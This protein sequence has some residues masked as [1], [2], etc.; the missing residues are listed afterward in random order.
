MRIKSSSPAELIVGSSQ[1]IDDDLSD[2]EEVFIRDGKSG[3]SR[4]IENKPLMPSRKRHQHKNSKTTQQLKILKKQ[5]KRSRCHR[6]LE[7]FCYALLVILVILILSAIVLTLFPVQKL[8]LMFQ[9][10][11][12]KLYQALLINENNSDGNSQ[13]LNLKETLEKVPCQNLAVNIVWTKKFAKLN[14]EAA[15]R[16]A[17]LDGDS[18]ED[19]I[20]GFGVDNEISFD[21]SNNDIPQCTLPNGQTDICEGGI[22]AINGLNGEVLWKYWTSYAIF[23]LFCKFDINSDSINDCIVSGPGGLLYAIDGKQGKLLWELKRFNIQTSASEFDI[24]SVDL[25]TINLMRDLDSDSIPDIISAHTDERFGIREGHIQLISAKT[26]KII[27]TIQSPYK[28]EIFVPIQIIQFKDGTEYLLIL[29][30]G[31]NTA[32]G[33]YKIRLDSFKNFQ[34]DND[35][36]TIHR[37]SSGFLVP[38][39]LSDLNGDFVEDFVVAS[40]NSTVFA[41]DG[42]TNSIMWS[43]TFPSSE[44]VSEIVPGY[45]NNDKIVD[46]LIK[47]S[48]GPGFPVYYY[49]QSTILD[50]V[51]GKSFL[52]SKITD[53]GGSHSLLGGISISQTFGGDFFLHFQSYCRDKF[54]NAKDP[55]KFIPDSD[56]IQQSRADVC[57]LRY[58]TSTVLKLIAL[59]RHLEPPGTLLFSSDM[60]P[61]TLN[62]SDK[63]SLTNS[64]NPLKHPKM[65][66]KVPQNRYQAQPPI[67]VNKKQSNINEQIIRHQEQQQE[68]PTP[69][70]LSNN[71]VMKPELKEL[72]VEDS[73]KEKALKMREKQMSQ[74][75]ANHRFKLRQKGENSMNNFDDGENFNDIM[76]KISMMDLPRE[77][78]VGDEMML[79][80]GSDKTNVDYDMYYDQS[81]QRFMP[82]RRNWNGNN[83]GIRSENEY[84]TPSTYETILHELEKTSK[85][86]DQDSQTVKKVL[87]DSDVRKISQPLLEPRPETLWD[88]EIEKEN[89]ENHK[90]L[91][92]KRR[93]TQSIDNNNIL[94][95]IASTPVLLASLNNTNSSIDI[96]FV[97]NVRESEAFPPLLTETDVQCVE[98]KMAQ[99]GNFPS[100]IVDWQKGFLKECLKNRFQQYGQ[101]QDL[102]S[103]KAAYETQITIVRL[104]ITCTCNELNPKREI[105][106]TFKGLKEQRWPEYMG[107]QLDGSYN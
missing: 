61:L 16:K 52:D 9:N 43:F 7:P 54:E 88:I 80:D 72:V 100:D 83:R 74:N 64:I 91:D 15:V 22:I 2:V 103:Q 13:S 32:G 19:I 85:K 33:I 99:L 30:G 84:E 60:I 56:I 40:F 31:Q 26:G 11:S 24:N 82:P 67:E 14:S 90:N 36:I 71:V 73:Q 18:I 94:P 76:N 105:C 59:S 38:A 23:S 35:Y 17:D 41:F 49:S 21:G 34:D 44:T 42:A 29:T 66:I 6:C 68:Q 62:P 102:Q 93:Q 45:Y 46:F 92:R 51:T 1:D 39:V 28:E 79:S 65:R 3:K 106:S 8:K 5:Y 89:R 20:I 50:G 63:T 104:S 69:M 47:Y 98:S 25:Y 77:Y 53:S 55:Y 95:S 58:N 57:A 4:E 27:R 81:Q 37:S 87:D 70:K 97:L 101:Q 96:V 75:L 78:K 107:P 12:P 10:A 48:T 86:Q